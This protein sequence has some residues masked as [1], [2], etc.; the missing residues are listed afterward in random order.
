M[1]VNIA[2]APVDTLVV[3]IIEHVDNR[4]SVIAEA[5]C[6]DRRAVTVYNAAVSRH[7]IQLRAVGDKVGVDRHAAVISGHACSCERSGGGGVSGARTGEHFLI[8]DGHA[9]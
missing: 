1:Y 5:A 7:D 2:S 9:V 8:S 3:C 6:I 4:R